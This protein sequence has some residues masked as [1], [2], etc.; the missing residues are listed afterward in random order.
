METSASAL[1]EVTRGTGAS[2]APL[3]R[4]GRGVRLEVTRGAE[5]SAAK[6]DVFHGLVASQRD[7]ALRL[8]WRLVDGDQAAAEDVVHDAFVKAYRG[9]DGFRG[10]A[11]LETWF[12]RILVR[13]AHTYR[14]WR[15][16]RTLWP[17]G[18]E[19]TH[20]NAEPMSDTE[21]GDPGLRRRI[22]HALE[23]LSRRQ[24]EAF[25]LVHLEGFS[26]K[27]CAEMMGSPDGTVKSHLHRALVKLRAALAD[28]QD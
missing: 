9:L 13:Q 22:A 3:T 2:A 16:V 25:V 20:T 18:R 14:R 7:R 17:S 27:E 15:A 8:A 26:V 23:T 5:V 4:E 6:E 12:Y 21:N 28:L 10:E 11:K 19:G 1:L 24:R